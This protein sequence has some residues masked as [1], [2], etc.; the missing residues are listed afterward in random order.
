MK[1]T[2]GIGRTIGAA[3]LVG[4]LAFGSAVK[5][6]AADQAAVTRNTILGAAAAVAIG[7]TVANVEHKDAVA[8]TIEGY[9]PDGSTVY[10][11]GHVVLP[12]GQTYYP[13]NVGQSIACNG[14]QCLISGGGGFDGYGYSGYPPGTVQ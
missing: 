8:S 11:D 5:P 10:E 2:S 1:L 6:A 12:N 14:G 9:T 7:L 3:V 4:A 13:G